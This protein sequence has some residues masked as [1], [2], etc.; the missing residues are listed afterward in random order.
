MS[1][2]LTILFRRD[3]ARDRHADEV[4][5]EGYEMFWPDGRPLAVGLSAFCRH[6]QRLM[7]LGRHLAG[8]SERLIQLKCFPLKGREDELTRMSGY[9]VR[10]FYLERRGDVGRLHFLDGTPTSATFELG[11]DEFRVLYW[12]GLLGLRDGE[13]LWID[14][15]ACPADGP[16]HHQHHPHHPHRARRVALQA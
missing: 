5:Y 10:R 8:R 3:P 7:G 9:R 11:R 1:R 16:I 12:V 13:R 14:L 2:T 6:G 15:A 4:H